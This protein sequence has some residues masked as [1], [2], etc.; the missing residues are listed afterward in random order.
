MV[1]SHK[2]ILKMKNTKANHKYRLIIDK[3]LATN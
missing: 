1:L 2:E 3:A